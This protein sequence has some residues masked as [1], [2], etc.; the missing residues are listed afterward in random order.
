MP[1]ANDELHDDFE[2]KYQ[3]PQLT[4]GAPQIAY[5]FNI[6]SAKLT[7]DQERQALLLY[8]IQ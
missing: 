5:L 3:I 1:P 7:Q 6:K 2:K 8:F 4:A